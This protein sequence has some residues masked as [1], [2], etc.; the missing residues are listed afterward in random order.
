[1]TS[2]YDKDYGYNPDADLKQYRQTFVVLMVGVAVMLFIKISLPDIGEPAQMMM[3][4]VTGGLFPM[5]SLL[6]I[7]RL[8]DPELKRLN[9]EKAYSES[10]NLGGERFWSVVMA[11]LSSVLA[12]LQIEPLISEQAYTL[13]WFFVAPSAFLVLAGLHLKN[14]HKMQA[15]FDKEW[16]IEERSAHAHIIAYPT[17]WRRIGLSFIF[18]GI[19]VAAFGFFRMW[20]MGQ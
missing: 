1:M 7:K 4:S 3:N 8:F 9:E 11:T 19:A 18:A 20:S 15:E 13:P 6:N 16:G 14:E 10:R 17:C 5:L 12:Y 2:H